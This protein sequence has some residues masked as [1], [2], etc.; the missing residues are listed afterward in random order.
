M[1]FTVFRDWKRKLLEMRGLVSPDGR[2]LYAYRLSDTELCELEGLLRVWLGKPQERFCLT[3]MTKLSGFSALFVLYGSEWWRRRFDGAHW[4]WDPILYDLGVDP[5]GWSPVQRSEFVRLGLQDWGLKPRS[6]GG[7]RFLGAVALQGGLPLRLLAEARGGIG[8]LLNQVL[9]LAAN[10]PASQGDLLTW[11]RSL[12]RFLPK[13][14]RQDAILV[15]LA[16]VVW[17]V[18]SLR[19]EAGLKPGIDPLVTLNER[20]PGWRDR[21]PL[22][23]E[24]EYAECLIQQLIRDATE[25]RIERTKT[26]LPLIRS[27]VEASENTWTL[28]SGFDLPDTLPAQ[29]LA[30][31]FG[32]E[33]GELPRFV[34]LSI[35]AGN[36]MTTMVARR[37][38]GVEKYRIDRKPFGAHERCAAQEHVLELSASDGRR[39]TVSAP[40]GEVLDDN[41][42]WIFASDDGS[43]RLV[44]QGGGKVVAVEVLVAMPAGWTATAADGASVAA[45]GLLVALERKLLRMRGVV[46]LEA[47][48]GLCCTLR[49][50]DA[51]AREESYSWKGDRL[52]L[53]FERPAM[54]FRGRPQL[55]LTG[56]D[57]SITKVDGTPG[58]SPAV[59]QGPVLARYPATGSI[60]HRSRLLVLPDCA[61]V[62]LAPHDARSGALSFKHWG[63][64]SARMLTAGVEC[65]PHRTKENMTLHLS[66]DPSQNTPEQIEI[67]LLWPHTTNTAKLRM[68]FPAKGVRFFDAAGAEMPS[69]ALVAAQRLMGSRMLIVTELTNQTITLELHARSGGHQRTHQL[70]LPADSLQLVVRPM[71]FAAEIHHLLSMDDSPDACVHMRLRI[72]G[73]ELFSIDIARYAAKLERNKGGGYLYAGKNS[74][75]SAIDLAGLRPFAVCLER[76]GDEPLEL[77]AISVSESDA[78]RGWAFTSMVRAPGSWLIYPAIDGTPFRPT[79]WRIDGDV[80]AQSPLAR[81][82]TIV[83]VVDREIALDAVI[84][85]MAADYQHEGWSE[86]EQLAVQLGH[87][88]LATLDLWRRFARSPEAMAALVFRFGGLSWEFI[89]RFAYELPFAWEAVGYLAWKT[90]IGNLQAQCAN[91]FGPP[92]ETV[93]VHFLK[94]RIGTLTARHGA[95]HYLLGIASSAYDAEAKNQLQLLRYLGSVTDGKLLGDED[96]LVMS[97]RRA[98]VQSNWPKGAN[99][100]LFQARSNERVAHFLCPKRF[101]YADG[102]INMPLLIAAQVA[103]D[104]TAHWFGNAYA[105]NIL[106]THRAFDPEWFDEAYNFT[107]SCCLAQGVLDT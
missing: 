40:R 103:S 19:D 21:F 29:Q 47:E 68:P 25:S 5:S 22:P 90:A 65:T 43:Y 86:L 104:S 7:L 44:R 84:A 74:E 107:I 83:N 51:S 85:E 12:D 23:V 61:D 59:G 18:L 56:E 95:L 80:M 52:W 97:L 64:A 78:D 92:G 14:Y 37:L 93:F 45:C 98:H 32:I 3:Q 79:L 33:A 87:L 15:L 53:D 50:G 73:G 94:S 100:I 58:W 75:L 35:R 96:S 70:H 20:T 13:T 27:L 89:D 55:Y 67:E 66:V 54:A 41:L 38:A 9:R 10:S 8:R 26:C 39:W 76:P 88:P 62:T 17:I 101:D 77:T 42:P 34:D 2:P 30:G 105:I 1:G 57:G 91:T 6:Q 82:L 28:E 36:A 24:D 16:D 31:L 99:P 69:G 48:D 72:G 46:S 102:A 11:V 63:V 106:R 71:D 81:T 49:T 4:S 60:A